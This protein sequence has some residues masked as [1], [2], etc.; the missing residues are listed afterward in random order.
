M[1]ETLLD[2]FERQTAN[3]KALMSDGKSSSKRGLTL[4]GIFLQSTSLRERMGSFDN[5]LEASF[6]S[7]VISPDVNTYFNNLMNFDFTC[8]VRGDCLV[9]LSQKCRDETDTGN[10][11]FCM[12]LQ[13]KQ[14]Q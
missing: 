3:G 11:S 8:E 14:Q 12:K 9:G 10:Y 1:E 4:K 13:A 6:E 5:R 7:N 2:L